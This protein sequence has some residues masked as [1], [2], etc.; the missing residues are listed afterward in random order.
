M[1]SFYFNYL[2]NP[3]RKQ[4]LHADQQQK[5]TSANVARESFVPSPQLSN[6]VGYQYSEP[7]KGEV[8]YAP[9]EFFKPMVN[10]EHKQAQLPAYPQTFS[11]HQDLPLQQPW[12]LPNEASSLPKYYPKFEELAAKERAKIMWEP[13]GGSANGKWMWMPN[14]AIPPTTTST[15]ESPTV[16]NDPWLQSWNLKKIPYKIHHHF[17]EE[18]VLPSTTPYGFDVGSTTPSTPISYDP[19]N[20]QWP[21]QSSGYVYNAPTGKEHTPQT[22]LSFEPNWLNTPPVQQTSKQNVSK[23]AKSSSKG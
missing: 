21:E 5:S 16:S 7:S 4:P 8:F 20:Y 18:V 1:Q 15:T 19:K 11:S 17:H 13:P 6:S 22:Q 9:N 12:R 2:F 14:D 3:H 10:Y 23:P